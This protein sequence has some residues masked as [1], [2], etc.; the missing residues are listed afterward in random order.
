MSRAIELM[1]AA[2]EKKN[3]RVEFKIPEYPFMVFA[4]RDIQKP[5]AHNVIDESCEDKF[6]S[7]CLCVSGCK[8]VEFQGLVCTHC[9][10]VNR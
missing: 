3:R 10:P 6:C 9:D 8:G 1:R 7:Q 4:S 5:H 2:Q